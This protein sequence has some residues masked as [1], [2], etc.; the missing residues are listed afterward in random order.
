MSELKS[1]SASIVS[2]LAFSFFIL[3]SFFA[4]CWSRADDSQMVAAIRVDDH[5]YALSSCP[6]VEGDGVTEVRA[7]PRGNWDSMP[8]GHG[9]DQAVP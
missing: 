6:R 8:D 4:A 2:F 5:Q 3:V 9:V 7:V 1:Y